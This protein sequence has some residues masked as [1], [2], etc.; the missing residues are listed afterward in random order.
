MKTK[1]STAQK[2]IL[3]EATRKITE[4]RSCSTYE[5]YFNKFQA[6]YYGSG[7]NTLE[8]YQSR[9]PEGLENLKQYWQNLL[10]GITF[11]SC[12]TKT[13]QKLEALGYIEIIKDANRIKCGLDTIK[14]LNI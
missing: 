9:D 13:I 6:P 5:E 10:Q 2:K 7:Y 14:V 12:N 4:A 8:K 1:L 11:T 3:D